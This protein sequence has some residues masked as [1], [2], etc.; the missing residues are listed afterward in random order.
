MAS[1][2][3]LWRT[4]ERQDVTVAV[5]VQWR[6]WLGESYPCLRRFLSPEQD[7][8]TSYPCERCAGPCMMHVVQVAE[9]GLLAVCALE[10]QECEPVPLR[11]G[12]L[13][14]YAFGMPRLLEE[15]AELLGCRGEMQA[16]RRLRIWLLGVHERT[17]E[18][19]FFVLPNRFMDYG[20]CVAALLGHFPTGGIAIVVPG[21]A[22]LGAEARSLL[23]QRH[24]RLLACEN[25]FELWDGKLALHT[26][27]VVVD[28]A[29]SAQVTESQA[30]LALAFRNGLE[31]PVV[32]H[33]EGELDALR[34]VEGEVEHFADLTL[35]AAY[36]SA[37]RDGQRVQAQLRPGEVAML[38]AY[39]GRWMEGSGPQR[40]ENMRVPTLSTP[41]SRRRAF[42]DLRRKLD[43]N[44]GGRQSYVLFKSRPSLHGGPRL[45]ELRPGPGVRY[46]IL[47]RPQ[48]LAASKVVALR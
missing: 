42:K 3:C 46:C 14:L 29:I 40:A 19:Y 20:L 2:N 45:H 23:S 43:R 25:V 30:P 33:S 26:P 21:L 18:P 13:T 16:C 48:D 44:A 22:R 34:A 9:Q 31:R 35:D 47:V 15:M 32:I 24:A 28:G 6:R 7:R 8:A 4:L 41:E 37:E 38:V 17:G 5:E 11:G 10:P 36:C 1:L 39:L 27:E 12:E